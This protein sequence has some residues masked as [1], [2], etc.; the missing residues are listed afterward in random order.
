MTTQMSCL[1]NTP[2][3]SWTH[4]PTTTTTTTTTTFPTNPS[5]L[6][7]NP[8]APHLLLSC[9]YL[10]SQWAHT[11]FGGLGK[12]GGR[13]GRKVDRVREREGRRESVRPLA[14]RESAPGWASFLDMLWG[15]IVLHVSSPSLLM[16]PVYHHSDYGRWLGLWGGKGVEMVDLVEMYMCVWEWD[17]ERKRVYWGGRWDEGEVWGQRLKNAGTPKSPIDWNPST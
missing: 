17:T 14:V 15:A 9:F 10:P 12:G 6:P 4:S 13:R 11:A 8:S 1:F 7:H 5:L 3:H 2:K 16:G